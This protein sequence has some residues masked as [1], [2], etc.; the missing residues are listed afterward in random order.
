LQAIAGFGQQGLLTVTA[1]PER[2]M[3]VEYDAGSASR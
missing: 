3:L 1:T 2:G